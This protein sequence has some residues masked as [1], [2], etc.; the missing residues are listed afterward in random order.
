MN[1]SEY[2]RLRKAYEMM[3]DVELLKDAIAILRKHPVR[4]HPPFADEGEIVRRAVKHFVKDED[5]AGILSQKLD[6]LEI[7]Y[8]KL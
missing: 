8:A 5:I 1:E 6:S 4:C 7:E 2:N 3:C